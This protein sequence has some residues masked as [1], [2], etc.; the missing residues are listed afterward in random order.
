M[1]ATIRGAL[2]AAV[3]LAALAEAKPLKALEERAR[4]NGDNLLNRFKGRYNYQAIPFCQ[5][6]LGLFVTETATV[7]A[8]L[9]E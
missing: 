1:P 6:Y 2:G 3:L 8:D 9:A 7:T 5:T 4:C